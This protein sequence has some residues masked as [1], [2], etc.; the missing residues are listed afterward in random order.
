MASLTCT[1]SR[2][3]LPAVA[4]AAHVDTTAWDRAYADWQTAN[5]EWDAL[6]DA[7]WGD[8]DTFSKPA[9]A[10]LTRRL[11]EFKAV[12]DRVMSI[13]APTKE[14]LIAKMEIALASLEEEHI[15]ASFADARRLLA[16]GLN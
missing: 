10:E 12:R 2:R 16:G 7:A 9:I 15:A 6:G 3:G 5:R 4:L 8:E 11:P 1:T 13:P 14:A